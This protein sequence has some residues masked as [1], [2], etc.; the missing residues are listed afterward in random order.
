[1]MSSPPF[2]KP[3][4]LQRARIARRRARRIGASDDAEWKQRF[5]GD[6]QHI[7]NTR[8]NGIVGALEIMQST[9]LTA[10]QRTILRLAQDSAESLLSEIDQ[11][12]TAN[13]DSGMIDASRTQNSLAGIRM[14]LLD[15]DT[16]SN[17]RIANAMLQRGARA[18]CF[19]TPDDALAAL[20]DAAVAGDP[21]RIALL[22]QRLQG[23][24]G[25]TLGM[26]I[27][28]DPM[29]RD[30]LLV[31]MSATHGGHDAGRLAQAGFSA[32]LPQPLSQPMLF[33]TL[34]LLCN[35]LAKKDAPH[36]VNAGVRLARDHAPGML[37]FAG[38]R[39]L[40]VDDNPLNL[41]VAERMLARLGCHVDTAN[42]GEQ[43]LAL[44]DERR[45]DLILMD[46][47]MPKLDGYQTT[48]LLRAA[49]NG[50]THTPIV[51]W[52]ACVSRNERD[53]CLAIGMDDFL[54]KPMRTQQANEIL[55]RWLPV[56]VA[57]GGVS[58][59][60]DD[61]LNATQ[62]MFGDDFAELAQLFLEDS[63]KRIASLRDA[64]ADNDA[65]NVA[66]LAHTLCGSTAS[67]GASALAAMCRELEIRANN[68]VLD[69]AALRIA[70][71]ASEYARIENRLHDML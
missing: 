45:Y 70:A 56:S 71:I 36:F 33:D 7:V 67:I 25:E 44:S 62:Q 18:D 32:W 50:K 66:K 13:T 1:M 43:A 30:T 46:C 20:S 23:M 40:V 68:D 19:S 38:Y 54:G 5:S 22:E 14:L 3:A 9:S 55:A 21:Y 61:E 48:A 17:V 51:G 63:P 42:G 24:A 58:M 26:A 60:P 49:E 31:L 12:L 37:P 35:C 34:T 65:V 8:M 47:R 53:T 2:Q 15:P 27:G 39:V 4:F 28:N 16:E 6:L 59:Q 10:D 69:E 57:V 64:A 41:Q 29:Y 52:S 11:L